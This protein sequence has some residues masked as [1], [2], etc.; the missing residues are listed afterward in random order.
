M[1]NVIK[2]AVNTAIVCFADE[3]ERMSNNHPILMKEMAESWLR[4]YP[5]CGVVVPD[6]MISAL[7]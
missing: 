7:V 2:G 5:N 4:V 6:G 3:P 1:M